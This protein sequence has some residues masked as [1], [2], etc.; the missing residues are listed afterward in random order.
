[1]VRIRL[2]RLGR[3][4][5]PFYRVVAA[6]ARAILWK[7]HQ[8]KLTHAQSAKRWSIFNSRRRFQQGRPDQ[9]GRPWLLQPRACLSTASSKPHSLQQ[10]SVKEKVGLKEVFWGH[11]FIEWRCEPKQRQRPVIQP[12]LNS[13]R[14]K[15]EC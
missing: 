13:I 14:T 3:K 2:A 9:H 6:D 1:M 11:D 5:R 10:R 7:L 15:F 8:R 12:R 4:R